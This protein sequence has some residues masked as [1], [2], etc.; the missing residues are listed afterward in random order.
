MSLGFSPRH[1]R[2]IPLL[3]LSREQ[4][5]V[6]A[7]ETIHQLSWNLRHVSEQGLIAYAQMSQNTW[8]EIKLKVEGD[9]VHIKSECNQNDIFYWGNNKPNVDAFITV[10]DSIKDSFTPEMLEQ[11]YAMIHPSIVP[12]EMDILNTASFSGSALSVFMPSEG[13]FITPLIVAVNLFVFLLMAL[14]GI[15]LIAPS[16][17]SLI[18]WGAN[19]TPLTLGGQWWR[20]LTCCFLHIG[21]VHLLMNM[22]A[23]IY[24]GLMLEPHLGKKRFLASYLITGILAS[25]TSLW[26]HAYSVSAGASG[27]IFGMYG[28]FLA[29]LTTNFIERYTR[30]MLFASIFI[31][32]IYNLANGLQ[33][34]VDNAA[35]IGGLFSGMI[36]GYLFLPGLRKKQALQ[37]SNQ[38]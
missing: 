7:I 9:T 19:Y 35:H 21:I 20:L 4:Y 36:M 24:I 23:L 5:L 12:A 10:F 18:E 25:A 3:P 37:T 14:S 29:M 1:I 22:Y 8:A 15:S 2:H 38:Q 33:V 27:A 30:K 28:V 26:W 17:Q 13:F 32:V 16:S 34:G 31:F 6:I 11:R